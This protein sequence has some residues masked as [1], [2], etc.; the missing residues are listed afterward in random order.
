MVLGF[1]GSPDEVSTIVRVRPTKT[2]VV[3]DR[4]TPISTNTHK[5]SGW[6]IA[7]Q[8]DPSSTN[9]DAAVQALLSTLP[10]PDAFRRLP[11]GCQVQLNIGL[12]GYQ[13]RPAVFLSKDSVQILARIGASL[14]VDPYDLTQGD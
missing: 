5:Q 3:G 1:D 11:H 13:Q 10:D 8:V 12:L 9:V 4:T 6:V 7:P 2:W 14:D